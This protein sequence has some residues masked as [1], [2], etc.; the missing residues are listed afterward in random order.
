MYKGITL[1]KLIAKD[2]IAPTC[3]SC[4]GVNGGILTLFAAWT[5][6]EKKAMFRPFFV[7]F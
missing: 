2:K 6:N 1:N 4:G 3:F 7:I 5:K